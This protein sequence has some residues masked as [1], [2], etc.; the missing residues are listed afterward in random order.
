MGRDNSREEGVLRGK[1][2]GERKRDGGGRVGGDL[3]Q[4]GGL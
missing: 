2:Q 3:G 1:L 4:R